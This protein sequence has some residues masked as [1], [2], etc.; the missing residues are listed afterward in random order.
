MSKYLKPISQAYVCGVC[1]ESFPILESGQS[2][3]AHHRCRVTICEHCG[4]RLRFSER[5]GYRQ[6]EC[7]PG[8]AHEET[9]TPDDTP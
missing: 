6:H 8:A 5:Y 3:F 4:E 1:G 2:A 9:R 7:Q